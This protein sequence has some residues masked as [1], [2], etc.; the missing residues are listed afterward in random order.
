MKWA[1]HVGFDVSVHLAGQRGWW[2]SIDAARGRWTSSHICATYVCVSVAAAGTIR[3]V[4]LSDKSTVWTQ[5]SPDTLTQAG[6]KWWLYSILLRPLCFQGPGTVRA[7]SLS[8]RRGSLGHLNRTER[9]QLLSRNI[10]AL[11][12]MTGQT[13]P[14]WTRPIHCRAWSALWNI[15]MARRRFTDKSDPNVVYFSGVGGGFSAKVLRNKKGVIQL[16]VLHEP[17][18]G[19]PTHNTMKSS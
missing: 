1:L 16:D 7:D 12:A 3:H 19:F 2:S 14:L 13:C 5:S 10:C 9:S 17:Q 8:R 4:R 11:P 15:S 6:I 18:F